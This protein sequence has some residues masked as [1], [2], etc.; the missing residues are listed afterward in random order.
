MPGAIGCAIWGTALCCSSGESTV[1]S[2]STPF[3]SAGSG[4]FRQ[5][6]GWTLVPRALG[7]SCSCPYLNEVLAFRLRDERLKFGR[8]ESV[9]E[10]GLR[11][12]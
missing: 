9:D 5:A 3:E 8:S 1:D 4:A 2:P 6:L 10:T 12:D 7:V 11:H